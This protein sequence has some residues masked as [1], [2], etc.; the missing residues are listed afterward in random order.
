MDNS[1]L[2]ESIE[3]AINSEACCMDCLLIAITKLID[4]DNSCDKAIKDELLT[5]INN[6]SVNNRTK[7]L[8]IISLI[9]EVKE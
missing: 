7:L 6:S 5:I 4:E 2:L 3:Q 8:L 1:N 9:N